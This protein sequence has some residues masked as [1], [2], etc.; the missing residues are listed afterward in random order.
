MA[1][2]DNSLK[3]AF[4]NCFG[5][6]RFPVKKQ[7]EIQNYIKYHSLDVLHLQECNINDDCFSDCPYI[8][9]NY[10]VITNNTQNNNFYGTASLV[11]CDIDI[12]NIRTDTDGRVIIFDAAGCTLCNIYLPS[13][14]DG[15][16]HKLRENYSSEVLPQ[17][18]LRQQEQGVLGG[19]LNSIIS[20]KDSN[21]NAST[22]ISPSFKTLVS[23]FSLV[24]SFR[25]LF[26]NNVQYSRVYSNDHHGEGASRIDR[27]YHWGD[28]EVQE[29]E[30]HSISFSDHLSL[31]VVYLLPSPLDRQ[32]APRARPQYKIPP[33]V[34]LDGEFQARLRR[35]MAIWQQ[36]REAGA[37]LATWWQYLVKGGIRHL[38]R[39]RGRELH[40]QRQGELNVLALRQAHL[41]CRVSQGDLTRLT[42][43]IEVKLRISKWYDDESKKVILLS[44]SRD[45]NDN[46]KVRI[47][48]H[49]IHQSL[50]QKSSILKLD[51]PAGVVE[52]H[53]ACASAIE[54]HVAAHLLHPAQ[55]HP[56]AQA[57][58]LAEVEPCF[59]QQD[60]AM[61]LAI[62][63]K[64]EVA[65]V[66]GSCRSHAAPGTDGMSAFVYKKC[67]D[68][69]GDALTDVVCAVFAG[70][71]PSNCQR[72][73]F[74][75]FGNKPGKKAKSLKISDRRK[76]SLLN[77]DFKV[78]TGIHAA[79]IRPTMCRT[80]SR[81]QL[82][83]GGDR[84]ISHGVALARDAIMAAGASKDECGILDTDL[85]AAFCNMVLMWCFSVMLKKGI[86]SQVI[87]MYQNLYNDNFSIIVVNNVQGKCIRNT[88]MSIRQG[89]KFAMELFVY[90]I[91]PVLSYLERRLQGILVHS[92]PVAGPAPRVVPPPAPPPA[93]LPEL[94]GL[95]ALPPPPPPPARRRP[96]AP[97]SGGLP[98]LETRYKIIGFCDDLKPSIT[99][100]YEF[101][102]VE[103]VIT[104]F[105]MASGCLMH[106]SVESQKC[107]F[108]PLGRWRNSLEQDMIPFNFFTLSEHLDFLGVTLK[109]TY[110]GTRKVNGDLLQERVRHTVGPWRA[111]RFM[112]MNLRA[113]SINSFAYS[114]LLY[115]L[116][117][118]DIRAADIKYFTSQ[119]K[120]FIYSD[121][122]E[123]PEVLVLN[124]EVADGGLGLQ[125]IHCRANA[126]LISTFLQTAINPIFNRNH[127]HN[128]LYRHYVLLEPIAAPPPVPPH[129]KGD[130]FP[131]IRAL[132][133]TGD[134]GSMSLRDVYRFLL[135]RVLREEPEEQAA[136]PGPGAVRPPGPA[137]PPPLR[138][139]R[140]ELA[141]PA[142]DWPR[143]WRLARLRGLEPDL[144]SFF[145]KLLWNILPCRERVRRIL[146]RTTQSSDC[147]LCGGDPGAL[148]AVESMHHALVTC[149]GNQG[150]PRLLLVLLQ[151]YMPGLQYE[152]MLT[153]DFN[154]DETMELPLVWLSGALLCSLWGQ[155]LQ[156]R[157]SAAKTRSELEARV[158]LLREGKRPGMQNAFVLAEIAIQ[159]MFR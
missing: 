39:Q 124:R 87:D 102:L 10:N 159:A 126:A 115:R 25:V 119:A 47:Y 62:P 137:A 53:A 66:L 27:S 134:P 37:D 71:K 56:A 96:A 111:G 84:R 75:V 5:Q 151:G 138:P 24:D 112:P 26:P 28:L 31:R 136:P 98:P 61:L 85:V 76:L 90:G 68:I 91:D 3:I 72:T 135:D 8:R 83:T 14:T 144:T 110:S 100:I 57:A 149:P 82:V 105:E 67:W 54:D 42:E 44:R 88:R 19:D 29:A 139:L 148:P 155:R 63:S 143:A 49:S 59:S 30:Y 23:S 95:P 74:M 125:H 89:D 116:N 131:S 22:K 97:R 129:F 127:Y 32:L 46:E 70:A 147:R 52:G 132:A 128:V 109:A 81:H 142:T 123:K 51:T 77:V 157:V 43:L 21:R 60:N 35:S 64:E 120:S 152:Q 150:L 145:L 156:G 40:L 103:R 121:M 65:R 107:K 118:I 20:L 55:L 99:N 69:L 34:V 92:M 141:T 1:N 41:A 133:E 79:R 93:P 73:S 16:S 6:N 154:L 158:R 130:F 104:F 11:R 86:S 15:A 38:A 94:P 4:I 33:D 7:L 80:T 58:L 108:L 9:S 45:I 101:H 17:L 113:H 140:C 36:V 122:L 12:T 2:T 106:R 78:M 146:P 117:V 153:L 48:H 114:K 50:R 18:L 13:G